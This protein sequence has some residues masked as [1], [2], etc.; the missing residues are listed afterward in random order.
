MN[1]IMSG[2]ETAFRGYN[3]VDVDKFIE[4]LTEKINDQNKILQETEEK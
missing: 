3:K 1:L 4:E 2:F